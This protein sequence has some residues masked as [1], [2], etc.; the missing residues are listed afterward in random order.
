[1]KYVR[2]LMIKMFLGDVCL[3]SLRILT[4]QHNNDNNN[5]NNNDNDNDNNDNVKTA[6]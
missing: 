5:N 3:K 2:T 6:S 1:M 4:L